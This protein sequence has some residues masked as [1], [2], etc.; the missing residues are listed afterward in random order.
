MKDTPDRI[1]IN[2]FA[3][4]SKVE[5]NLE[6]TNEDD[7]YVSMIGT[8]EEINLTLVCLFSLITFVILSF[9]SFKKLLTS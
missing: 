5:V 2:P 9:A 1:K 4:H 6:A 7:L 8:I 3:F